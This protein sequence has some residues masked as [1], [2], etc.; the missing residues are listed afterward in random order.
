MKKPNL[1]VQIMSIPTNVNLKI[2]SFVYYD[3]GMK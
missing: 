3:L 1:E 2:F